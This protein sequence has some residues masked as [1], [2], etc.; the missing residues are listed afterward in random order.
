MQAVEFPHIQVL[1][2]YYYIHVIPTDV[3]G[4]SEALSGLD[5]NGPPSSNLH[6]QES[7]LRSTF[8][9]TVREKFMLSYNY[10]YI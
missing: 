9:I 7:I 3:S 10:L 8:T 1:A 2:C 5:R 6:T 4:T